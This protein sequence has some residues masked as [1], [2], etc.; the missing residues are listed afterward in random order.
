MRPLNFRA[1]RLSCDSRG[2]IV[3][4]EEFVRDLEIAGS[5]DPLHKLGLHVAPTV[6]TQH[7]GNFFYILLCA[8]TVHRDG[9]SFS[10]K[11][12]DAVMHPPG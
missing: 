11:A 1:G 12:G 4:S 7:N 9:E 8:G 10:V 6:S 2:A 5:L 3:L